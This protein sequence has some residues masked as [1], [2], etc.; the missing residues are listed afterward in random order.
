MINLYDWRTSQEERLNVSTGA[1]TANFATWSE[2]D[3]GVK[4]RPG[5]YVQGDA[6]Y[7]LGDHW[8]LGGFLRFDAAEEFR[9]KAG[10][11][12]FEIDPYGVTAGLVLRYTLP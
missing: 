7:G 8:A 10:P 2:S 1:A 3:S 6:A 5:L 9:V 11:T 4:I 12:E